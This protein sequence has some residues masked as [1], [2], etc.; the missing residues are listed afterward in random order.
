MNA[1]GQEV[2]R[3]WDND[4]AVYGPVGL[5]TLIQWVHE[6]RV[7]P[8]TFIQAETDPHWHRAED[9]E[10]LHEHLATKGSRGAG[11]ARLDRTA[12]IQPEELRQFPVFSGFTDDALKQLAA[13]GDGLEAPPGKLIV[14]QGDLCDAVYF[15]L[16][17][18]VGVRLVIGI[19][20]H[21]ETLCRIS[22]GEF[23]GE[24]GMFLGTTRT[25]DV[26]AETDARLLRVSMNAFQLLT[27]QT[28]GLAA[29]IL[30]TLA[31]TMA[32]RMAEDNQRF[33]REVTSG[34][35]WR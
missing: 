3:V 17:G 14:K 6:D 31:V 21:E 8:G 12:T 34:F 11:P 5:S 35:L 33:A 19:H 10:S 28:P 32:R 23:F 16:S 20:K 29:P 4:N 18:A 13:L 22:A 24:V 9:F 26:V 2:F 30:F 25:A 7:L 27:R 1:G 15:V